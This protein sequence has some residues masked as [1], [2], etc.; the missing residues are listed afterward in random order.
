[1][2]EIMLWGVR[3]PVE[4]LQQADIEYL[5]SI[6]KMERPSIEWMWQEMDRVWG[7]LGLDNSVALQGQSIGDFYAH[8]VWVVNGV[9][10][11]TDPASAQHRDSIASFVRWL[12][13]KRIADYGGGFGELARRLRAVSPETQVDIVE[14]YPSKIGMQRLDGE[15][16]LRFVKGFDNQY[17]CV[18]AQDVLEHVEQP[19]DLVERMVQATKPGGYLIV[20]NCFYPV[21]KCHLPSTFYLRHTFSWVV[22]GMGLKFVGRVEGA[23]HVLVFQ[24]KGAVDKNSVKRLVVIAKFVGPV[25]NATRSLLGAIE[26]KVMGK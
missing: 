2:T 11:A 18:I 25:L 4:V 26:R 3:L 9:F 5:N 10:T 17:D 6:P 24:R 16:G 12:D 7:V 15:P 13:V 1:M 22:R 21:I 14:P 8:P 20:A 19:L 23:S